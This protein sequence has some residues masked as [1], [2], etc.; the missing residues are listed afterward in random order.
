MEGAAHYFATWLVA[1]IHDKT[2]Y[3]SQILDI[4]Y[5]SFERSGE[6]I[7][8]AEPDKWGAAALS[9]MVKQNLITEDSI[10]DGSLFHNCDRELV[11]NNNNPEIQKIKDSWNLIE[12]VGDT[13][14]FNQQALAD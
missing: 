11:F 3:L 9:L 1:E 12:K 5:H 13:Y 8:D 14:R 10:L 6:Q 4:A 2:N 7:Y